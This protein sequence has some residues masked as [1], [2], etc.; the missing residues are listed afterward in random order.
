MVGIRWQISSACPV[1]LTVLLG[2]RHWT[3]TKQ[4]TNNTR[5]T[6]ENEAAAA[7]DGAVGGG[8]G[9]VGTPVLDWRRVCKVVDWTGVGGGQPNGDCLH[10][11][12]YTLQSTSRRESWTAAF[13]CRSPRTTS[14][15]SI[16]LYICLRRCAHFLLTFQQTG[17][18]QCS[19]WYYHFHCIGN[20]QLPCTC[21]CP[22]ATLSLS[23]FLFL[24]PATGSPLQKVAAE[25]THPNGQKR[26]QKA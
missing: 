21:L 17:E 4:Y 25:T 13:V 10:V 3:Y 15:G 2:G 7:L 12:L 5:N 20:G 19:S 1:L 11:R 18:S 14:S 23:L 24:S 16:I 22:L 26:L 9:V 8:G 6:A